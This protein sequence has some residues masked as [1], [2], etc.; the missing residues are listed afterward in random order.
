MDKQARAT[1][2]AR[3]RAQG[4]RA[5]GGKLE[6]RLERAKSSRSRNNIDYRRKYNI[7]WMPLTPTNNHLRDTL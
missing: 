6:Y 2:L 5:E 3:A 7:A 1:R 4:S